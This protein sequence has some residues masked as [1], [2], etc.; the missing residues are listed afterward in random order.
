MI[1]LFSGVDMLWAEPFPMWSFQHQCGVLHS[2]LASP[3]S[4]S[5]LSRPSRPPAKANNDIVSQVQRLTGGQRR[6]K[7][8]VCYLGVRHCKL[9]EAH[10]PCHAGACLS[11]T[12]SHFSVVIAAPSPSMHASWFDQTPAAGGLQPCNVQRQLP[13]QWPI[14]KL[15]CVCHRV[16]LLPTMPNNCAVDGR[17]PH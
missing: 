16:R 9:C 17:T 11:C 8:Q 2:F 15:R 3:A 1:A 4:L 10:V 6:R 7:R 12:L 5:L 14:S 13:S